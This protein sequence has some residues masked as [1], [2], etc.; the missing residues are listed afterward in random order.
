M[1]VPEYRL[2]R[3][4]REERER[5]ER[6][7][8]E[9]ERRERER[10]E[11]ELER[12]R[13]VLAER[14]GVRGVL[15]SDPAAMRSRSTRGGHRRRGD[16]DRD[17]DRDRERSEATEATEDEETSPKASRG[18]GSGSGGNGS[19]AGAGAGDDDE[20]E[21]GVF[22]DLG[23]RLVGWL[24]PRGSHGSPVVVT[25]SDSAGPGGAAPRRRTKRSGGNHNSE[26]A[27][28]I[29]AE[30][31]RRNARRPGGR[32]KDRDGA[33]AGAGKDA[34]ARAARARA[35]SSSRQARKFRWEQW[36]AS[37][38][39]SDDESVMDSDGL[40]RRGSSAALRRKSSDAGPRA[41]DLARVASDAASTASGGDS[42]AKPVRAS[43]SARAMLSGI[44]L[45]SA[46][47]G[48]ETGDDNGD[49]D[50][51]TSSGSSPS[52]AGSAPFFS[53]NRLPVVGA[54]TP[55]ASA[56]KKAAGRARAHIEFAEQEDPYERLAACVKGS[57]FIIIIYSCLGVHD[58]VCLSL[59]SVRV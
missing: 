4:E 17:R 22:G 58:F 27:T 1:P 54:L 18:L 7:A 11:F 52:L 15:L 19:G 25:T 5:E 55:S 40:L 35:K 36:S 31:A 48:S 37:S 14:G 3:Q 59:S 2:R 20:P 10:I 53:V 6:A 24:S 16:R 56:A 29:A 50:G 43:S 13:R 8:A 30:N 12:D 9:E 33:D 57:F 23:S 44:P 49:D 21:P 38:V 47:T 28:S 26:N 32:G 51:D 41:E 42:G 34:R 46:L 39:G 45:L